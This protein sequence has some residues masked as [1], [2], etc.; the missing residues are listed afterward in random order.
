MRVHCTYANVENVSDLLVAQA[1]NYLFKDL[2]LPNREIVRL[3]PCALDE[4]PR[5]NLRS[6]RR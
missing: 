5:Q 6:E 3:L 1:L 2:P 4:L